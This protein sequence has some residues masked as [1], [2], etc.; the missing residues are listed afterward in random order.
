MRQ[1]AL[2]IAIADLG[3]APK[4]KIHNKNYTQVV[5]RVEVFRRHF[6]DMTIDTTIVDL[7]S[8]RVL[9]RAEIRDGNRIIAS[10][11]A[12]EVR[13]AS[14]INRTSAVEVAETS[15]VGR[16]LAAFGLHGGE[17][18]SAGEVET[19]IA[20]QDHPVRDIAAGVGTLPADPPKLEL[21]DPYGD[22]ENIYPDVVKYL[23]ALTMKVNDQGAWWPNNKDLVTWIGKHYDNDKDLKLHARQVYKLGQDAWKQSPDNPA[24][25][26]AGEFNKRAAEVAVAQNKD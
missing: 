7:D 25:K 21:I 18:A 19:A 23:S 22:V 14:A 11:H 3:K 4:I 15:A 9:M 20:Q 16:A 6:P 24:N 13:A 1:D 17:Y 5:S 8:E 12:E 26:T 2:D 10:G